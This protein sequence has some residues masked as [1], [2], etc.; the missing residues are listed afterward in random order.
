MLLGTDHNE[1]LV[2][3]PAGRE[4]IRV[5]A[6]NER[7]EGDERLHFLEGIEK[8]LLRTIAENVLDDE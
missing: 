7:L 5:L 6:H 1:H 4:A 3:I 2:I 8:R